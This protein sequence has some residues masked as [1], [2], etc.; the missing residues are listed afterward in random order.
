M[1]DSQSLRKITA[2]TLHHHFF[3]RFFDNDTL[4]ADG[5]MERS[6]VR[7]LCICSVPGLMVAF[8]LLPAYPGRPVWA[9]AADRYFFVLCSFVIMG[10]ATTFEWEMLFPDRA[11]FLILLPLPIEARQL[12]YAKGRALLTF[13]ALFL[14]AANI[15]AM[16]LFPAVST[17]SHRNIVPTFL[18]HAA[19]TLLSGIFSASAMLAIEGLSIALLPDAWQR[20]IATILQSLAITVL[21]LLFLLFP[22]FGAHMQTLLDGHAAFVRYVPPLWFLG[23]Y[24][25]LAMGSAAPAGSDALASIGLYATA[26]A[27]ILALVAYPLAWSRQKKRAMEGASQIRKPG[28]AWLDHWLHK[29]LLRRPQ[30]RAIFHF[31]SHTLRRNSRYQVYLAIYSGVGLAFAITSA[32]TLQYTRQHTLVLALSS[33]GLHA[34]LPLL[35]FWLAVGLRVAFGF[36]VDMLAR[37][38]FPI[39]LLRAGQHARATGTWVMLCC[40]LLTGCVLCVLLA[41]G[42]P[43]YLLLQQALWGIAISVLLTDILFISRSRIP[44]TQPRLPGRANLPIT[45]VLYAAAFPVFVLL[46]VVC[47]L[48][49]ESR[50]TVLLRVVLGIA[51]L[52]FALRIAAGR[53]ESS[54]ALNGYSLDEPDDEFQTLGLSHFL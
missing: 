27:S 20:W 35:L 33:R 4:S 39:N 37:W 22:L 49:S 14:A 47:E 34:V 6:V 46:T 29:T 40:A 23:L 9:M 48:H 42:W 17:G 18:V 31:I 38:I 5:D 54:S 45:L 11:D 15:F 25:H 43:A 7:S 30:E 8:W 10:I 12:F 1:L 50:P 32:L 26:C 19:S 44:F 2:R 53:N 36:P 3:R 13:L 21:L 51:T 24:E 41:L 16:I 52:H 28:G